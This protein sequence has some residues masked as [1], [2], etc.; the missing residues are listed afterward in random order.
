MKK[1][2]SAAPEGAPGSE[3]RQTAAEVLAEFKQTEMYHSS[4]EPAIWAEVLAQELEKVLR[5][6]PQEHH[7]DNL[8][9][10]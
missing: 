1:D 4:M 10:R 2:K 8:G 9:A 6:F 7:S 3:V 5:L